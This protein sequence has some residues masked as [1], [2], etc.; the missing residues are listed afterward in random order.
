MRQL[1]YVATLCAAVAAY[2][3][4]TAQAEPLSGAARFH[5]QGEHGAAT[6][7]RAF[8]ADGNGRVAAVIG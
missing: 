5:A 1:V 2:A 4:Q 8:V 7:Q 6:G 3:V